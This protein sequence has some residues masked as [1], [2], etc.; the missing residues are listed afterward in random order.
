MWGS[1]CTIWEAILPSGCCGDSGICGV[2][3]AGQPPSLL[4]SQRG[5]QHGPF[6]SLWPLLRERAPDEAVAPGRG[7]MGTSWRGRQK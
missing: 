5:R 6:R 3:G 4:A 2:E 7:R 1:P